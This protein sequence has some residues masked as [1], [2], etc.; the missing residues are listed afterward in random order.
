[1]LTTFLADVPNMKSVSFKRKQNKSLCVLKNGATDFDVFQ[2]TWH[3]K[4][5][6]GKMLIT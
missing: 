5:E 4:N 1:V 2:N 6:R 3:F